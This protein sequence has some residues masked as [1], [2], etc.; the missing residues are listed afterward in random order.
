MKRMWRVKINSQHTDFPTQKE[1]QEHLR[2]LLD[3]EVWWLSLETI[4]EDQE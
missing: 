3:A 1:A 2:K 4:K